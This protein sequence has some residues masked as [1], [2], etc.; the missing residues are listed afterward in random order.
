MANLP[1]TTQ[2]RGLA[3]PATKG[4]GGFFESKTALDVAWGDLLLT[5]FTPVG[6][7]VMRRDF[8]SVL[9]E[10]LFD[11]N[12]ELNDPIIDHVIREAASDHCPQV[13]IREVSVVREDNRAQILVVFSLRTDTSRV[14]TREIIVP[15]V[16]LS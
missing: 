4:P 16:H 11:A 14:Q 13:V 2:L 6:T 12:S 3:L 9:R 8:G 5:L 7:R 1:T 10:Q 15:K